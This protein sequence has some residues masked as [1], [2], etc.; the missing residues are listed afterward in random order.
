ML[1]PRGSTT[2]LMCDPLFADSGDLTKATWFKDDV[3][4]GEVIEST[5]NIYNIK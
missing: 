2:A 5:N 1:A 3:V 4:I